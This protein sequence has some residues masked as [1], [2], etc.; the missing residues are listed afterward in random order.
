V[1]R[2]ARPYLIGA[3]LVVVATGLIGFLPLFGGPGYEHTLA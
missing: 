1:S 2:V 3:V